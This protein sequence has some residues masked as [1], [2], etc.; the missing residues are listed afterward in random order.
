MAYNNLHLLAHSSGESGV[1]G[2]GLAG[3]DAQGLIGCSG[4]AGW[5]V[6]SS[7]SL[8]GED[9]ASKTS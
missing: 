3:P 9:Y 2:P 6:F 8:V 5:A 4:H 7:G 1:L